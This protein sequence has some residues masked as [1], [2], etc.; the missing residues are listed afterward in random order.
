MQQFNQDYH[1]LLLTFS[2]YNI[3][4]KISY[5]L[6]VNEN[7]NNTFRENLSNEKYIAYFSSVCYCKLHCFS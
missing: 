2:F 6:A 5:K 4:N 7:G 3:N 1:L